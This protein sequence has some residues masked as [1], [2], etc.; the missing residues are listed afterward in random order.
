MISFLFEQVL[1]P[2]S[3]AQ[4]HGSQQSCTVRPKKGGDSARWDGYLASRKWECHIIHLFESVQRFIYFVVM[5]QSKR[6]ITKKKDSKAPYLQIEIVLIGDA[7]S[8][9]PIIIKSH[10]LHASD[11]R[12]DK[13]EITSYHES[14]LP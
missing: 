4:P 6:A 3:A 8:S 9:S 5:G 11:I 12:E 10:N 14:F 2:N 13:G 1:Q 7:C